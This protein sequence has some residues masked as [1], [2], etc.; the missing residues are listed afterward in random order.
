MNTSFFETK[1]SVPA[2]WGLAAHIWRKHWLY[3]LLVAA[4]FSLPPLI[5]ELFIPAHLTDAF[6]QVA[7]DMMAAMQNISEIA[8][9][10]GALSDEALRAWDALFLSATATDAITYNLI[11]LGLLA[12]FTP[13]A[14]GACAYISAQ[15]IRGV[16]VTIAGLLEATVS[17]LWKYALTT[18]SLG[19]TLYLCVA[20]AFPLTIF[21]LVI[22]AFFAQAIALT[23]RFGLAALMQSYYVVRRQWFRTFGFLL[24]M[25]ALAFAAQTM[26]YSIV[27]ATGLASVLV[28]RLIALV[29]CDA[30][31]AVFTLVITLWYMNR[32][33]LRTPK[34]PVATP[35]V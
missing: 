16:P 5:I 22:F 14:I 31:L 21:L 6:L 24:F 27:A 18:L 15:E 10:A 13:P 26:L 4:M 8:A 33:A 7:A 17:R 20:M 35:E 9:Q 29:L 34:P 19:C 3:I 28:T 25:G 12:L 2:L 23:N 1:H 32:L 30:V 11:K